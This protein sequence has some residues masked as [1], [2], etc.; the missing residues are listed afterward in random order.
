LKK[1]RPAHPGFTR[2]P[3]LAEPPDS[4]VLTKQAEQNGR[5]GS[6]GAG[7][8]PMTEG[9]VQ[10]EYRLIPDRDLNGAGLVYFA[11]YP[12]FLDIAE[13]AVLSSAPVPLS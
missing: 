3:A 10:Q 13:R 11:N 1:G 12:M 2:I 4:S 9:P 8:K 6:P 5:F 7:W